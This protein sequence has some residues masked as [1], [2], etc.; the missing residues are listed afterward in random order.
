M[1]VV[2]WN[3]TD[4]YTF[5]TV[6][7]EVNP[8]EGGTPDRKKTLQTQATAAPDGK[9]ILIEGRDQPLSGSF[10]GTLLTQT[11][12]D[13]FTT[14]FDKRHPI[15]MTDDLGREFTIY[16]TEYTTRRQRAVHY[17]YKHTYTVS[18]VIVDV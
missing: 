10:S 12:L 15:T 7:F 13:M 4:P 8:N 3:F 11:Q 9:T 18:Y 16:I 17:P 2:S 5:E 1:A 14:W 6:D